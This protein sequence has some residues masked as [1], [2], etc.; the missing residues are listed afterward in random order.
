M[1][2]HPYLLQNWKELL[3]ADSM[4]LKFYL[5]VPGYNITATWSKETKQVL[6]PMDCSENGNEIANWQWKPKSTRSIWSA[7]VTEMRKEREMWEDE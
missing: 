2:S 3:Y 6:A 5:P 1:M 4:S 7:A